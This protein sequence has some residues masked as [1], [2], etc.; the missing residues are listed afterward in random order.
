VRNEKRTSVVH[1]PAL[2]ATAESTVENE[3]ENFREAKKKNKTN[4]L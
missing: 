4:E 2:G 3:V 1:I